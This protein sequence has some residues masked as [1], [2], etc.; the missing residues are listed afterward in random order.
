MPCICGAIFGIHDD[1][2]D[3]EVEE[4]LYGLLGEKSMAVTSARCTRHPGR[5]VSE[6]KNMGS[7]Q[8]VSSFPF[9]IVSFQ[10]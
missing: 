2:E 5:R 1:V 3:S 9:F 7:T 4:A 10:K 6:T 8:V